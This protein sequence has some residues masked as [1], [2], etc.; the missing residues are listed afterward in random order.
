MARGRSRERGD[1]KGRGTGRRKRAKGR[2][3]VRGAGA[4]EEA[5]S[6]S[7]SPLSP[8]QRPRSPSPFPVLTDTSHT[9]Y[10]EDL[11]KNQLSH[12]QSSLRRL[13]RLGGVL[14][15]DCIHCGVAG[16]VVG[17]LSLPARAAVRPSHLHL[18]PTRNRAL[19]RPE[20]TQN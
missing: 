8:Q 20:T 7:S 11:L 9:A 14:S 18:G 2:K 13:S 10:H 17:R 1:G 6:V 19:E 3:R 4:E 12:V 5:L 15:L 16:L